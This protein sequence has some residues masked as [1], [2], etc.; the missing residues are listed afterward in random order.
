MRIDLTFGGIGTGELNKKNLQNGIIKSIQSSNPIK[1]S[2]HEIDMPRFP[3]SKHLAS[4]PS[5]EEYHHGDRHPLHI[6]TR[7]STSDIRPSS[8]QG[9]PPSH[10][11][12]HHHGHYPRNQPQQHIDQIDPNGVFHACDPAITLRVR[13]DVQFSKDTKDCCP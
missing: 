10:H 2:A 9:P 8:V 12:K 5:I 1:R 4:S 7:Q 11:E 6:A 13:V 3:R